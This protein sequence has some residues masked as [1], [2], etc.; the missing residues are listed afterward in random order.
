MKNRIFWIYI[1]EKENSSIFLYA[2]SLPTNH[3]TLMSKPKCLGKIAGDWKII[4]YISI[5]HVTFQDFSY[6]DTIDFSKINTYLSLKTTFSHHEKVIQFSNHT[7]PQTPPSPIEALTHIEIY[8]SEQFLQ[9]PFFRALTADEFMNICK[10]LDNDKQKFSDIYVERLGCFEWAETKEWSEDPLPFQLVIKNQTGTFSRQKAEA[11]WKVHL[12]LYSP[13]KETL[14]DALLSIKSGTRTYTFSTSPL[15][16]NIAEHEYWIFDEENNL[17]HHERVGYISTISGQIVV[18]SNAISI[19]D[20]MANKDK[21]LEHVVPANISSWTTSSLLSKVGQQV[22]QRRNELLEKSLLA[23]QEPECGRWFRKHNKTTQLT[24][25]YSLIEY[26]NKI[27]QEHDDTTLIIIDPFISKESL[28]LLARLSNTHLK[29]QIISCWRAENPDTGE[30]TKILNIIEDTKSALIRLKQLQLSVSSAKWNNLPTKKFH[31]RFFMIKTKKGN[32][33]YMLSN[34]INNLLKDYDF[35]IVP[36]KGRTKLAAEE[37]IQ[38]LL[39]SCN[40]TNRIF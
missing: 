39:A 2:L 28:S 37:Y 17:L 23:K 20:K 18:V 5:Q 19:K 15:H 33:I 32:K 3:T 10:K 24:E 30:N 13:H 22:N 21:R 4:L 11:D 40:E 36:L 31:D 14:L 38:T 27:T 25:I 12:I 9:N 35:C 6:N 8:Y 26:F 34:S 16:S 29:L 7:L 1:L